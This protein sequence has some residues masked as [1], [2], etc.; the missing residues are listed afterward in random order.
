MSTTAHA[1]TAPL[2][3][4]L[5]LRPIQGPLLL[6]CDGRPRSDAAAVTARRL[7]ER[8]GA[9]LEVAAVLP[10]PPVYP[11]VDAPLL[12][13]PEFEA[14]RKADLINRVAA[15]LEPILGSR[16][17][18][19]LEVREGSPGR[20][21]AELARERRA[22]LIVVGTGS[23]RLLDRVV[24]DEVSL[25]VMRRAGVP[26]LA[27]APG[28][29]AA[30]RRAVAG[31]D[32]GAASVI[33]ARTALAL[34]APA[35]GERGSL[36]LVHVRGA[37]ENRLPLPASWTAE[38]DASVGAMYA[39]LRELLRPYLRDDVALETLVRT[40]DVPTELLAV[41]R[42][43][44]AELVAVGTHGPGWV[45]RLVVGSVATSA[46]RRAECS[47][48][49]APTPPAAERVRLELRV[50]G[51]VALVDP[52]EWPG[53]LDAFT[54]RNQLRP[55]RLEVAGPDVDHF[56]LGADGYRF[57]GAAFDPKDRRLELMFAAG[58]EAV[59]HLTHVV[60]H[61]RTIEIVAQ[62]ARRDRTLVVE[63][64]RGQTVLTL[65]D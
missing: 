54:R 15:R 27:V 55:A 46:L 11:M 37:V 52:D 31:V 53:A 58:P 34:L 25:Q 39:R 6:G 3:P 4:G 64:A 26:V 30:P 35:P 61:V 48:L 51:Q 19:H 28:Q 7:A 24:G 10:P 62:D 44:Q 9:R 8:L 14:D 12:L 21:L 23:H 59:R 38:Y 36:T 49:V 45:E 43:R 1:T 50:A 5:E 42:D 29:S 33:A 32:F 2:H 65:A 22:G 18:W 40:G 16:A 20:A 13:P 47:V 60:S 57:L 41:A 63:D 56:A 17:G